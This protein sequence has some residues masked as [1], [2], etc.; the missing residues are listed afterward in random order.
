[1]L[2]SHLPSLVILSLVVGAMVLSAQSP[3]PPRAT[4]RALRS[5]VAVGAVREPHDRLDAGR[6]ALERSLGRCRPGRVRTAAGISAGRVA[7]AGRHPSRVAVAGRSDALRRLQVSVRHD[8]RGLRAPVSSDPNGDLRRRPEH[9]A[10]GRQPALYVGQR[11]RGL[12]G[13]ARPVPG[14]RRPEHRP[15]ARGHP[16]QHAA[17]QDHRVESA[18]ADRGAW[19]LSRRRRAA[20]T[21]PSRRFPMAWPPPTARGSPRPASR[22]CGRA[23]SRPSPRCAPF[24][25]PSTCPPVPTASAGRRPA[26]ARPATPSSRGSSRRRR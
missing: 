12:A 25:R 2:R 20:T 14:V 10:D 26:A 19:P 3:T 4:P 1:M 5:H 13:A 11:L 24:S 18:A 22:P 6:P 17:A 16:H 21:S 8:G 7:R 15:A 23:S 9:R